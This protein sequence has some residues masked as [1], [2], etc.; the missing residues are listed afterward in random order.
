MRA[1]N[2][3]V[4]IFVSYA[5][6]DPPLFRDTLVSLLRWPG[7]SVTVWTD[8]NIVAGS[9]PDQAIRAELERMDI[10][11]ALISPHF[12]ASWYI[13]KVEVPIAKKRNKKGEVLIAPVVVNHPG[14]LNCDWLLSLERLPHKTK[15]WAE[16]RKECS[17]CKGEYDE[18]IQPLRDGVWKLVEQA[19]KRRRMS[20]G[21]AL[22]RP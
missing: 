10:F 17:A 4:R 19:R 2:T 3:D 14:G 22:G 6:L 13:H 5:H 18:A 1:K 12:D 7:V 8:E 16:I 9:V 20:R 21:R 11:V 15:S